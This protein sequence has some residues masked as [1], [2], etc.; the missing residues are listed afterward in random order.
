MVAPGR[1]TPAFGRPLGYGLGLAPAPGFEALRQGSIVEGQDRGR[2]QGGVYGAGAADGERADRDAGRHLHDRQKTILS[3]QRL[4]LDW[5]AEDRQGGHRG[6]HARQVG[7]A[8]GAGDDDLKTLRL[9]A[10]GEG[11]E[12]VRGAVRRD[13]AGLV[14]DREGV[15]GFGRVAHGVPVRLAAHDD[16]HRRRC[17]AHVP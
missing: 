6:G 14:R 12:P 3:G 4:R 17:C 1:I 11:V 2:E 5:H 15:Q 16:R 10:L 9:G 8:A 13:D 7:G